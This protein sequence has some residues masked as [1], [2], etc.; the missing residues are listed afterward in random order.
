[1]N[2]LVISVLGPDG[3]GIIAAVTGCLFQCDCNVENV[4]QTILQTEFSGTF[5]VSAPEGLT[6]EGL[7]RRLKTALDPLEM[8]PYVKRLTPKEPDPRFVSS[9]PFVITTRGPD[10]KGL[11]FAVADWLVGQSCNIEDSDQFADP[12]SQRF[13]STRK[14]IRICVPSAMQ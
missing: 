11:V 2:K 13:F 9:E 5:I 6:A 4:S 1:M 10:R 7:R 3:P 14:L 12:E 8:T